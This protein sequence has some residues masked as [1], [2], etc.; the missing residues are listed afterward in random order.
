MR[1][2]FVAVGVLAWLFALAVLWIFAESGG[3]LAVIAAGIFAGVAIVSLGLLRILK[4]LED[5]R[6]GGVL[7]SPPTVAREV[8]E[9]RDRDVTSVGTA[10]A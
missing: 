5:I 2:F 10:P 9:V 6:G 1:M 7:P 8:V 4:V 3:A